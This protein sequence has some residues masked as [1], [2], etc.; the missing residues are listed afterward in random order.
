MQ[1][2]AG[3]LAGG[4]EER[5]EPALAVGAQRTIQLE[6]GERLVA[7]VGPDGHERGEVELERM[8]L[9][10]GERGGLVLT[11]AEPGL[12]QVKVQAQGRGEP[13]VEPRLAFSVSPDPRESDTRRVEPAE[14]TAY[15]GGAKH[16]KVEGDA[17]AAGGGRAIPLWS[18][19]LALALG[20]FFLEGL[21]ISGS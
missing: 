20:A 21:L 5:R 15:F 11:P 16:A 3:F 7:L 14:L 2:F 8:G 18:I 19:L 17:Q 1:R 12:W 6:P 9:R 4:L 13:R 10:E